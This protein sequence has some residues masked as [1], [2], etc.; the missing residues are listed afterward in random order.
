ML[1][2]PPQVVQVGLAVPWQPRPAT[3]L[4]LP[5]VPQQD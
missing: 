1:L 3:Q 4:K 2:T 5:V